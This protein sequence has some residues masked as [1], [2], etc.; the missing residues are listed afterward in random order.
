MDQNGSGKVRYFLRYWY[1]L[2]NTD[3][4]QAETRGRPY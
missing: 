4:A 3:G 2:P 1:S